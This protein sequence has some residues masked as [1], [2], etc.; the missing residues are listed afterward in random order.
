MR[1][2][3]W[4]SDVCS[5]DLSAPQPRTPSVQRR[6]TWTTCSPRTT[7]ARASS[8]SLSQAKC[9]QNLPLIYHCQVPQREL[10]QTDKKAANKEQVKKDMLY[11]LVAGARKLSTSLAV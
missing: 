11:S 4:S 1:I 5:S 8:P 10:K 7:A 6:R 3:D 2:S 9:A